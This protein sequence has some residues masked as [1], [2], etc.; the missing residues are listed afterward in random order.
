MEDVP[1]FGVVVTDNNGYITEFQEK[2]SVEEAKSNYIN[3]GIYIFDYKIFD[4]IPENTFYD[5]AKNVFPKLVERNEINTFEVSEYWSDIGTINQYIQ[6]NEDVFL[7][8]CNFLHNKIVEL[9]NGA[10]Y[11]ADEAC[12]IPQN[13]T[14]KGKSVIGKNTKIGRNAIIENSI[15]WDNVVISDDVHIENCVIASD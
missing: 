9:Q 7:G 12:I 14:F 2:P 3:T 8:K 13:V 11:I 1:H 10:S 5:F 4:Y 15:I 6:S